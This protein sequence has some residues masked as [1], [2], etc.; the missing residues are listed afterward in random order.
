[1]PGLLS[2]L[3][4]IIDAAPVP[5]RWILT[6]SRDLAV[7]QPLDGR[8][9]VLRLLPLTWNEVTRFRPHP[10]NLD[11]AMFGGGY[12]PIF[13][14][15]L[16]PARWLSRYVADHIERDVRTITNVTDLATFQRFVE[17]CARR[18]ARLLNYS[19]LAADCGISQ[20]TAKA[21]MS[22]LEASFLTFRLPAFRA[23][24]GKRLVKA[25]KLYFHDTGLVCSLLG[26]REPRQLRSHPLRGAV[27]E[28]W[29]VSEIVK[30][31]ANRDQPGGLWFY[32]D[33]NGA[34][35]DLVIQGQTG[36]T[37]V[38]V[39]VDATVSSTLF[40]GVSRVRGHFRGLPTPE[41]AVVYGGEGYR[42]R[43]LI[44]WWRVH[45]VAGV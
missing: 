3:R 27:F 11:D 2:R 13:D 45:V 31:R 36:V 33:R 18:S 15:K 29:V 41:I 25:P 26:I 30:H 24:L 1:M 28:S 37:L 32:R 5:G 21:W 4:E 42:S 20:P 16:D 22:I 19:S 43:S 17:V 9:A 34:E 8:M 44:P 38:D 7:G 10:A 40:A 23:D 39:S 12:P 14:R 6:A 35:A